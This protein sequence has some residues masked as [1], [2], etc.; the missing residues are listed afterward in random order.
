MSAMR[1]AER[2]CRRRLTHRGIE[3]VRRHHG[4]RG[5]VV[6]LPTRAQVNAKNVAQA[7]KEI[8]AKS[9]VISSDLGQSGNMTHP[10]G[11]ES[12]IAAMKREGISDA[13]IDLMMRK[14]PARLL[15]L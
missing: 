15:G 2:R 4:G 11:I 12:A 1:A 13:D 6:W 9:L 5:K 10:D 3:G 8:G 14:N 7:L